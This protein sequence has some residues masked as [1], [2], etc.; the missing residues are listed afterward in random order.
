MTKKFIRA[1]KWVLM[2]LSISMFLAIRQEKNRLMKN[3]SYLYVTE[4]E[5][6]IIC[7]YLMRGTTFQFALFLFKLQMIRELIRLL[8]EYKRAKRKEKRHQK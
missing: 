7:D 4:A 6:F 8:A 2:G 3:G 5:K 1:I